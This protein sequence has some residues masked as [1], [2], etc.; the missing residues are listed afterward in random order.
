MISCLLTPKDNMLIMRMFKKKA[1]L[2]QEALVDPTKIQVHLVQRN[3][4]VQFVFKSLGPALQARIST[5]TA[6]K[7]CEHADAQS[8]VYEHVVMAVDKYKPEKGKCMFTSFLWTISN[9]AFSNFIS[10]SKR[11]K[12]DPQTSSSTPG[13]AQALVPIDSEVSL[14][15]VA[16]T[17]KLVSLDESVSSG[18]TGTLTLADVVADSQAIEDT[19]SF[20]MLQDEVDSHCNEQ[21]QVLL[22]LL[23][24]NYTYKEIADHVGLTPGTVSRQIQ[25]L[26]KKLRYELKNFRPT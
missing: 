25:Q 20:S 10:A 7:Y 21:Q 24:Q 8:L 17:R 6:R 3:L 18:D 13:D 11:Q 16:R 14:A 12:R 1:R 2:Q 26:R 19:L 23:Q 4:I 5:W 9:R 22:A 15:L